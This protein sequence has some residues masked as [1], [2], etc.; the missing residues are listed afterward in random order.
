MEVLRLIE[1]EANLAEQKELGFSDDYSSQADRSHIPL[2]S[3][4]G[5]TVEMRHY[6]T[7]DGDPGISIA[8]VA[9]AKRKRQCAD[10]R[11][12]L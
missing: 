6:E 11:G 12:A 5:D 2:I 8:T 9:V 3:V 4:L 1:A 10:P 7:H